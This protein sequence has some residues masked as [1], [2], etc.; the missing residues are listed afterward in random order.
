MRDADPRRAMKALAYTGPTEG[1]RHRL[2]ETLGTMTDA[3]IAEDDGV[4]LRVE[5]RSPLFGFVDDVEFLF[6][7]A[8]KRIEFRSA[9]RVGYYDFGANRA[10]MERI[11]RLVLEPGPAPAARDGRRPALF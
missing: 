11:G 1:A 10:R 2:I 5:F 7:D 6:D 9:S 8:L 3:R 4:Y